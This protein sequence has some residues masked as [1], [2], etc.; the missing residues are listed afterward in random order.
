MNDYI[1][2]GNK[3]I[4]SHN[5]SKKRI[6]W[7]FMGIGK[8]HYAQNNENVIDADS[9]MFEFDGANAEELHGYSCGTTRNPNY[10][11]NYIDYI[12]NIPEGIVLINC[13][14]NL[15]HLFNN[16]EVFYPIKELKEEYLNRYRN[17]GDIDSFIKY[18][19]ENFEQMIHVIDRLDNVLKI[20]IKKENVYLE[21]VIEN[22]YE[23]NN[24]E[25]GDME[26]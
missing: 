15:L 2:K 7:G 14:L 16:V 20:S 8:S 25:E 9:M 5:V 12:N 4:M 3:I 23:N 1:E 22:E 24:L 26:L 18:M 11:K 19:D 13:H 6:I 17:R 21:N 10:P